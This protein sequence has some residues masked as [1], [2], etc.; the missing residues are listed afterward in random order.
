MTH[1]IPSY[2]TVLILASLLFGCNSENKKTKINKITKETF[3]E[4]KQTKQLFYTIATKK[5]E[6]SHKNIPIETIMAHLQEK[7]KTPEMQRFAEDLYSKRYTPEEIEQIAALVSNPMFERY[8]EDLFEIT[9]EA[10]SQVNVLVEQSIQEIPATNNPANSSIIEVD[11]S[12]FEAEILNSSLPV[13][14]DFYADWCVPCK[15]IDLFLKELNGEFTQKIRFARL[16]SVTQKE[17][18]DKFQVAEL[19]FI[20]FIKE[21]KIVDRQK[22][23][24][25]KAELREKIQQLF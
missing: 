18:A 12:N 8:T 2:F 22:G 7:L 17:I 14:L 21:G 20:L 25:D 3:F 13:V 5:L 16:N 19:P 15:T 11:A 6:K 1:K 24:A 10:L 23:F 4:N 9:K